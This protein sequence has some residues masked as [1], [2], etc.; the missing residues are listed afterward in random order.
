MRLDEL[1]T[2]RHI[3]FERLHHRPAYTANRIAQV[4]HVPGKEV[5]KTVLLRTG[6][7]YAL[8]VLPATHRVNLEQVRQALGEEQVEMASEEEMDRLFPD[9]ERGAMP[10]FGSL[11]H[12]PTIVDESLAEDEQIVFEAQN[13]E[14]AIRMAYRDY[15]AL[16]QPRKAHFAQ[17]V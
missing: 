2:S 13:H 1:L 4:L 16:E 15:E 5:A 8:A 6:H 7:G 11:Y 17:H 10:P 9:C 14:E 12:L 3:P